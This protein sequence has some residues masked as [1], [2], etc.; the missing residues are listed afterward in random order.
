MMMEYPRAY[1]LLTEEEMEYTTGG[2][3][4]AVD[5]KG[6]AQTLLG[7]ASSFLATLNVANIAGV[8]AQIQRAYPDNYPEPENTV[9]TQLLVDSSI[10]YFSSVGGA[11]LGLVNV[12]TLAGYVYCVLTN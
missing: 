7:L 11:L 6:I 10:V 1:A 2:L 9:N 3:T 5:P 12:G 8:A 4:I